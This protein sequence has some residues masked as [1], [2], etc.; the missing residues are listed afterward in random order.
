MILLSAVHIHVFPL[1][2]GPVQ[3]DTLHSVDLLASSRELL[4]LTS[5]FITLTVLKGVGSYFLVYPSVCTYLMIR[6]NLFYAFWQE[7][8]KWCSVRLSGGNDVHLSNYW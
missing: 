6:L 2:Q 5:F 7:L 8:H 4:T 1:I 3:S